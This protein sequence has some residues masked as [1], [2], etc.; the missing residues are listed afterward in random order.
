[1]ADMECVVKMVAKSYI[2]ASPLFSIVLVTFEQRHLL[3]SCLLSIFNQDY[4]NIELIV[5]DDNSCDFD[6]VEVSE[7]INR[8]KR[9]NVTRVVVYKQTSNV[10][11]VA[12]CQKAYTL[13]TGE[14]LKF[15]AGDDMLA[16]TDVLSMIVNEFNISKNNRII[17]TR[18]RGC[19]YNGVSTDDIYPSQIAFDYA[20]QCS[21]RELFEAIATI[22]WGAYVCAPAVFWRRELLDEMNGFDLSYAVTEDWPMWLKICD[23]EIKPHYLDLITVLYRYGGISTSSSTL[24]KEQL[25]QTHLLESSRMLITYA[26]PILKQKRYP[27]LSCLEC[28]YSANSLEAR[29]TAELDWPYWTISHKFFWRLKNIKFLLFSLILKKHIYVGASVYVPLILVATAVIFKRLYISPYY[30]DKVNYITDITMLITA[31]WNILF[32]LA[33]LFKIFAG[34]LLYLLRRL[35]WR[36][37]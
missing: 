36:T 24:N 26:L 12:N 19:E 3:N 16:K 22:N 31:L 27:M 35:T 9:K 14:Y 8:H 23:A 4:E 21:C 28:W 18:A 2:P 6:A 34:T 32:L 30:A 10:G 33:K 11:T 29:A 5:C 25:K 1:M 37:F 7:Y 13:T 20:R 17:F 15:H